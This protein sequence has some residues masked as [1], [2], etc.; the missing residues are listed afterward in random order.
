MGLWGA[1]IGGVVGGFIGGP[2]GAGIGAGLGGWMSDDDSGSGVELAMTWSVEEHSD[3]LSV[4]I[5]PGFDASSVRAYG[6]QIKDGG[7]S[8]FIKAEPGFGDD[9]GDFFLL[10][11]PDEGGSAVFFIP[12]GAYQLVS[13]DPHML[14]IVALSESSLI[15]V[16]HQI[17]TLPRRKFSKSRLI[18]PLVGLAMAVARA[19]GTLDPAE[20][21][22]IRTTLTS[23]FEI[24]ADDLDALRVVMKSEP[25]APIEVLLRQ[26]L[27]RVPGLSVETIFAVLA[28]VAKA[29]GVVHPR[30]VDVIRSVAYSLGVSDDETWQVIAADLGLTSSRGSTLT[31]ANDLRTA[32]ETLGLEA[33]ADW[34]TVKS[35]YRSKIRSYHPDKVASLAPEFQDLAK[36]KSQQI[37][38]AYEMLRRSLNVK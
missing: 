8:V 6:L 16:S 20:V 38:E 4:S 18:R 10:R 5:T 34:E 27:D 36:S 32:Y 33:G 23:L 37:N 15:G 9:D 21:S 7:G 30:E 31:G 28:D 3:G 19:D 13:D 25:S 2:V 14:L 35:A 17:V 24:A 12:F 11:P 26:A 1:I 22:E 29:D